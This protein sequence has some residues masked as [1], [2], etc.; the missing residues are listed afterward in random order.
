MELSKYQ[1]FKIVQDYELESHT[2]SGW[3]VIQVLKEHVLQ[4][5]SETVAVSVG[6]GN[7]PQTMNVTK[8]YP[9]TQHKYLLGLQSEAEVWLTQKKEYEEQSKFLTEMNKNLSESV[10]KQKKE[11]ETNEKLVEALNKTTVDLR[12]E[13]Q[14]RVEEKNQ[15]KETVKQME[16]D[17]QKVISSI[18]ILQWRDILNSPVNSPVAD[19]GRKLTV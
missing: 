14:T 18:G 4:S 9:C 8:S 12:K 1:I 10:L 16:D 2:R 5:M 11:L 6:N 15:L 19:Y 17:I 7:Y 3:I 13:I